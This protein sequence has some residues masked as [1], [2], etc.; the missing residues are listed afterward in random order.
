M[1]KIAILFLTVLVGCSQPC[2]NSLVSK[3]V[4]PDGKFEATAFIRD[5]GATTDFSPQVYLCSKGERV[6]DVG[7]VFIGNHS[8]KIEIQWL[9]P[10]QLVVFSECSVSMIVTNFKGITI[11]HTIIK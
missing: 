6:K 8:D 1:N 2:S 9:S 11:R 10:T 3:I 7:N 4:S 5:C